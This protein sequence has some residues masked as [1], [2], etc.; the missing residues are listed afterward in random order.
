MSG[1]SSDLPFESPNRVTV[2]VNQQQWH[3]RAVSFVIEAVAVEYEDVASGGV[4][5]K[6]LGSQVGCRHCWCAAEDSGK[7]GDCQEARDREKSLHR[8]PSFLGMQNSLLPRFAARL[9]R[10]RVSRR[11][12]NAWRALR[13][14][15]LPK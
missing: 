15:S 5:A 7:R 8:F 4:V 3:A 2:S 13:R 10:S 9:D 12:S 14:Y 1:E 6:F 11:C